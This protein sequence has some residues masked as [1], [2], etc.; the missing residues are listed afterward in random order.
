MFLVREDL[1]LDTK[2]QISVYDILELLYRIPVFC[3]AL[4]HLSA[5]QEYLEVYGLS[6]HSVKEIQ[7]V[8]ADVVAGRQQHRTIGRP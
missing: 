1:F 5:V 8:D 3:M 6:F 7:H 4:Q 2:Q